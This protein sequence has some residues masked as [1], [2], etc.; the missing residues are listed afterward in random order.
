MREINDG[1]IAA[2][3]RNL[4]DF[5][6]DNL[7]SEEV[8]TEVRRIKAGEEA[9]NIIGMFATTMLKEGGYI[10]DEPAP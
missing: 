1:T 4:K 2:I 10:A 7:T 6:Y 5:G 8:A 9:T 3:W